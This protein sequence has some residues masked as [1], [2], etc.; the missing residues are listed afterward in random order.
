[1]EE[2]EA[3]KNSNRAMG[4][5]M[6]D[7]SASSAPRVGHEVDQSSDPLMPR[8]AEELG[9]LPQYSTDGSRFV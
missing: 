8:S 7:P 3:A 1:M 4:G 6:G 5:S 9:L 2:V